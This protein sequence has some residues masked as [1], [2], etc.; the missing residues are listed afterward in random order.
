MVDKPSRKGQAVSIEPVGGAGA[1]H[2]NA[3][4]AA[5]AKVERREAPGAAEHDAD[6]DDAGKNSKVSRAA[7]L[8]TGRVNVKA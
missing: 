2:T 1:S 7:D 4:L 3:A 6:G 8:R 5:A